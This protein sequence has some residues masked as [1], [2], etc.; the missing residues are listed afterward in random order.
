MCLWVCRIPMHKLLTHLNNQLFCSSTCPRHTIWVHI[1]ETVLD[2]GSTDRKTIAA[3]KERAA[4][5]AERVGNS[6]TVSERL[7]GWM[8][9]A[10]F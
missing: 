10:V 4:Q 2:N 8:P 3:F 6:N 5:H 1:R 7:Q 9:V